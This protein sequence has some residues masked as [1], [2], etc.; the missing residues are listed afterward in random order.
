M[1][2]RRIDVQHHMVPPWYA[3]WL[4][5]HGIRD[6]GGRPLPA[7]S[8]DAAGRAAIDRGNAAAL[9]RKELA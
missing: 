8:A 7:W 9:F 1:H 3:D 6:A 4:A 5:A 2:P